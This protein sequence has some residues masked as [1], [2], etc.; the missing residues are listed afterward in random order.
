MLESVCRDVG[1]RLTEIPGGNP[2][3]DALAR[4]GAK[5]RFTES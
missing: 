1:A 4:E 5:S 2:I 3:S